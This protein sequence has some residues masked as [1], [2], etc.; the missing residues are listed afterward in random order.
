[1]S[2]EDLFIS[3]PSAS[4]LSF[5]AVGRDTQEEDATLASLEEGHSVT[6]SDASLLPD[7]TSMDQNDQSIVSLSDAGPPRA[8]GSTL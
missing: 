6:L 8:P 7:L 2:L 5:D 4:S 3:L 1:M